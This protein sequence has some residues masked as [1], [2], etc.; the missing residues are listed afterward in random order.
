[1]VAA[2]VQ[3]LPADVARAAALVVAAQEAE[4]AA[5][6]LVEESKCAERQAMVA[7]A[8]G[9]D[10]DRH[11][12]VLLGAAVRRK[13][14]EAA[15]ASQLFARARAQVRRRAQPQD[16]GQCAQRRVDGAGRRRVRVTMKPRHLDIVKNTEIS[17]S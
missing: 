9:A 13:R 14:A 5:Q 2:K 4:V 3:L 10:G 12:R 16:H 7:V 11:E 1:M 6:R 15:E 17:C 8:P